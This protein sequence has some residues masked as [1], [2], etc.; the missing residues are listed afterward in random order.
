MFETIDRIQG[1]ELVAWR[2]HPDRGTADP[3]SRKF[4]ML[5]RTSGPDELRS[6]P[7]ARWLLPAASEGVFISMI[8]QNSYSISC[9]DFAVEDLPPQRK[10]VTP[11]PS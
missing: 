11:R 8:L 9:L 7:A 2:Q 3:E 10:Q 6:S 4:S 5:V 1:N